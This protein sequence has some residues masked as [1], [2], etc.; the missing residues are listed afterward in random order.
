[1][2]RFFGQ[3]Q[4]YQQYRS[5]Q[6]FV[7]PNY[8]VDLNDKVDFYFQIAYDSTS[9]YEV[10]VPFT[11]ETARQWLEVNVNLSDLTNLKFEADPK[12]PAAIVT[13]QIRDA[14]SGRIYNAKLRG[15][16]TL[17]NV[18]FLYAGIRNRSNR[19]IDT[20]E[21]WFDDIRLTAAFARISTTRRT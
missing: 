13:K 18:R 8:A 20:G 9:Y 14:V 3:G 10:E 11:S 6:F 7:T 17:F 21:I 5:I 4:N 2:K 1:M 19:T 15:N 16:P 12:H